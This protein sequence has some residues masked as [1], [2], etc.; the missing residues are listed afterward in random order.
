MPALEQADADNPLIQARRGTGTSGWIGCL[1]V[2][3]FIAAATFGMV[4]S[5]VDALL[6]M[7]R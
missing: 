3:I 7:I 4:E 2:L 5:L 6:D 1:A